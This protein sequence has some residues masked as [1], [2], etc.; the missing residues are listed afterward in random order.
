MLIAIVL[1]DVRSSDCEGSTTD[2][3][4][5][6]LKPGPSENGPF[7]ARLDPNGGDWNFSETD[8]TGDWCPSAY[9]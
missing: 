5:T 6:L 1:S 2:V 4:I 3:L 7:F 9:R 8:D